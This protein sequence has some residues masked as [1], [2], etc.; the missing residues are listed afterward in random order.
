MT[1]KLALLLDALA[2]EGQAH[3]A[4][5]PDHVRRRL[6]LDPETARLIAFLLR[7]GNAQRV[8]EIGTSNG[9]GTIWIASAVAPHGGRVVSIDRSA[10]KIAEA[11]DNLRKAGLRD[12]VELV[13]GSATETVQGLEGLFDAVLFDADRTS[14]PDQLEALRDKLE[15]GALLLADN[16]LSHPD[17][18]AAY[19]RIVEAMPDSEHQIVAVGKGLSL[20][21]YW[22]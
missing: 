14:A 6:N 5:E 20:A 18:I 13:H 16:A 12:A 7:S 21:L 9:Y 19:L 3:D 11:A 8:L 1:E 15:P 22:P 10:E 2:R 4:V 17:E